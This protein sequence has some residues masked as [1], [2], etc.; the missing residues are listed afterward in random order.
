M[1]YKIVIMTNNGSNR[2]NRHC[3]FV[4][5]KRQHYQD[6]VLHNRHHDKYLIKLV[7]ELASIHAPRSA[8]DQNVSIDI[9]TDFSYQH[10]H[11]DKYRIVL[12]QSA[13]VQVR[14]P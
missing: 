1:C 5:L 4:I 9:D 11:N 7:A 10:F 13:S 14:L 8:F 3:R 6:N 2:V 12:S